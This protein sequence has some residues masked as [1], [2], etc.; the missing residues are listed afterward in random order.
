MTGCVALLAAFGIEKFGHQ[1]AKDPI[2]SIAVTA[3]VRLSGEAGH[4]YISEAVT[5]SLIANLAQ[6]HSL[7]IFARTATLRYRGSAKS[8]AE[9]AREL[10]ADA[11]VE[12]TVQ[13]SGG[14][15]RIIAH[16]VRGSTGTE[17]WAQ[18]YEV[19]VAEVF[20]GDIARAIAAGIQ[21]QVTRDESRRLSRVREVQPAAQQL[22]LQARDNEES[23]D[24][25]NLAQSIAWY[26]RAISLEPDFSEAYAA[27]ART[28]VERGVWGNI[29]FRNAEAPARRAA[30]KALELDS[31]LAEAHAVLGH[32]LA[33][34]D[35]AWTTA[36]QEFQR[37]IDLDPNSIYAHRLY[38]QMLESCGR[39]PGRLPS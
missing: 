30:L 28:W 21:A 13:E 35:W 1:R 38:G 16:L 8:P 34:Y 15:A 33:F 31:D 12:G 14:R 27:L 9:I 32:I 36:E 23:R 2:H 11:I 24:E 26:E 39:P 7:Q 6:I 22:Y 5:D 10:T 37:A 29:G 18:D 17:I 20:K 3:F 4:Q 25:R 19:D